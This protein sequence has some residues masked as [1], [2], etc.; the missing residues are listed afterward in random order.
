MEPAF[1]NELIPLFIFF[2]V[3]LATLSLMELIVI[4]LLNR[5]GQANWQ[6]MIDIVIRAK[7]Y[8]GRLIRWL[9]II[10]LMIFVICMLFCTPL[11]ELLMTASNEMRLF[12]AL[13]ALV[14]V[15]IGLI[16]IRK[17]AHVAIE[18]KIYQIIFFVISFFIYIFILTAA[19]ESYQSYAN[20]IQTQLID[21]TVKT[22]ELAKEERKED[23]LLKKFHKQYQEGK[24]IDADYTELSGRQVVVKSFVL[25]ASEP[26]LAFSD[27]P[28]NLEDPKANLKGKK[29]TDGENT[30]LLTEH[31]NWYWITEEALEYAD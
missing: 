18:R 7:V 26:I 21:P 27:A 15:L 22:M 9:V 14:M 29:C 17:N 16:N 30:F 24:C 5:I 10:A 11:L 12:A 28:I 6:F 25:I 1:Y 2:L 4:F 23:R 8:H 19:Q 13:L 3:F 31:G 20:Y